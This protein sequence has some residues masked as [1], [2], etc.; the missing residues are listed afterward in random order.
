MRRRRSQPPTSYKIAGVG[1]VSHNIKQFEHRCDSSICQVTGKE[2]NFNR[3]GWVVKK[4]D[5]HI[6]EFK[7]ATLTYAN[8]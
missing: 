6:D 7:H 1:K 2:I 4:W 3:Q 5:G 8:K